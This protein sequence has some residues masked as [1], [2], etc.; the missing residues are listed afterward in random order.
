MSSS[1]QSSALVSAVGRLADHELSH[2]VEALAYALRGDTSGR[3][4]GALENASA[5]ELS[6]IIV[7]LAKVSAKGV[8]GDQI[9]G[10]IGVL[11]PRLA[12]TGHI[13]KGDPAKALEQIKVFTSDLEAV[14]DAVPPDDLLKLLKSL[15]GFTGNLGNRF[16][17]LSGLLFEVPA[18]KKFIGEGQMRLQIRVTD[19]GVSIDTIVGRTFVE[20]KHGVGNAEA[21]RRMVRQ[22]KSAYASGKGDNMVMVV[23]NEKVKTDI[24]SHLEQL[25]QSDKNLHELLESGFFDD[26]AIEI[27]ESI[28]K[29]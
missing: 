14:A 6:D 1:I 17:F 5:E 21:K 27:V 7:S 18:A 4:L 28:W 19:D 3:I 24:I 9:S 20:A 25:R 29:K 11:L 10:A 13:A 23:P 16:N 26:N 12:S 8:D 22:I 15:N 2:G